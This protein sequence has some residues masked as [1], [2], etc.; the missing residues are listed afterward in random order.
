MHAS[1]LFFRRLVL[2]VLISRHTMMKRPPLP[3]LLLVVCPQPSILDTRSCV[4]RSHFPSRESEIIARSESERET[5]TATATATARSSSIHFRQTLLFVPPRPPLGSLSN[6]F[7]CLN[8]PSNSVERCCGN[9]GIHTNSRIPG[10]SL[11]LGYSAGCFPI[12]WPSR[13][14]NLCVPSNCERT[15]MH[16]I[17]WCAPFA[18][19]LRARQR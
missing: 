6:R 17:I 12:A 16:I 7:S 4:N 19:S 10:C 2:R 15:N 14:G 18:L 13:S 5:A 11:M 9:L 3:I 8:F 1:S